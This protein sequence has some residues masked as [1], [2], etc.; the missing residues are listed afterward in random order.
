MQKCQF[1]FRKRGTF[2][3]YGILGL[4]P[5]TFV[6][7]F[8]F[9]D[10]QASFLSNKRNAAFLRHRQL[11]A[12]RAAFKPVGEGFVE[13]AAR[14]IVARFVRTGELRGEDRGKPP[15]RRVVNVLRHDRPYSSIKQ[16]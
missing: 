16:V 1:Q 13:A 5:Q 11:S 2:R 4:L 10:S 3:I 12:R 8:K 6:L 9:A 15:T 7:R 14:D